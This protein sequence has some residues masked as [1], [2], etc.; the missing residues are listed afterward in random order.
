M[1]L[2]EIGMFVFIGLLFMLLN[3]WLIIKRLIRTR[4]AMISILAASVWPALMTVLSVQQIDLINALKD[5][6]QTLESF[7]SFSLVLVTAV[8]ILIPAFAYVRHVFVLTR[9]EN[10]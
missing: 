6:A 8:M 4:Y 10:K 3:I 2:F 7:L 9:Q 1:N 5:R